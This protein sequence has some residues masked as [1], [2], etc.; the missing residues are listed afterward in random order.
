MRKCGIAL[1]LTI[2][3][4]LPVMAQRSGDALFRTAK[5]SLDAYAFDFSLTDFDIVPNGD[6]SA[7]AVDGLS[8]SSQQVGQPELPVFH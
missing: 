5:S 6:Y 3:A 1:L 7:I 8:S 2:L 4:A